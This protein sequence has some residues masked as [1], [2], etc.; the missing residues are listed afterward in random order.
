MGEGYEGFRARGRRVCMIVTGQRLVVLCRT[1][2][3]REDG[4]RSMREADKERRYACAYGEHEAAKSGER[5]LH[6]LWTYQEIY[7]A[8]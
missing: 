8:L 5:V 7:D 3:M 6:I 4:E 2:D 1:G